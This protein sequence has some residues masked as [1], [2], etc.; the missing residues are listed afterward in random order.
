MLVFRVQRHH[1]GKGFPSW[2]WLSYRYAKV[3]N[4]DEDLRTRAM[5]RCYRIVSDLSWPR[6]EGVLYLQPG[7]DEPQCPSYLTDL[8]ITPELSILEVKE[9]DVPPA[10]RERLKPNHDPIH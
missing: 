1:D 7:S 5:I 6:A 4:T 3:E 2:S 9:D 10:M 8:G